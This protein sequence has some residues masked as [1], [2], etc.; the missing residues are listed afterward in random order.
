MDVFQLRDTVI[1]EYRQFISGFLNVRDPRIKQTVADSLDTGR[2]WPDPYV[3]LN[4]KNLPSAHL[5][6]NYS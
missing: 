3:S 6:L 4:P 5:Y 1:G 2:L